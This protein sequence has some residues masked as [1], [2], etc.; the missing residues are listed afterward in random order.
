MLPT[1]PLRCGPLRAQQIIIEFANR[2]DRLLQFPIG[3]QST[4]YLG[5]PFAAHAE[6]MRASVRICHRRQQHRVTFAA[7]ATGAG[8]IDGF[9]ETRGLDETPDLTIV[10]FAT[11]TAQ[12]VVAVCLAVIG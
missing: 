10:Q 4:A 12:F 3:G 5:N 9:L 2:F 1:P 6:L 7:R 11:P 8:S